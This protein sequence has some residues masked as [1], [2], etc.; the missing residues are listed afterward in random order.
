MWAVSE[1]MREPVHKGMINTLLVT[2]NITANSFSR[3]ETSRT[4]SDIAQWQKNALRILADIT[5]DMNRDFFPMNSQ[6]CFNYNRECEYFRICTATAHPE[7]A[8]AA[9]YDVKPRIT[10]AN[11][12]G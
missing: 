6:A 3:F 11:W 1:L 2:N 12:P 10:T 4:P 9:F 7:N 8:I 5:R